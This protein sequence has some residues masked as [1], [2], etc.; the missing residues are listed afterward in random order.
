M[1][2][3][4]IA[5]P[6]VFYPDAV[7]RGKRCKAIC[8]ANGLIGLYPFDNEAD[9]AEAIFAGNCALIDA[10]DI[11]CANLNPFRGD[12]PDS[13]TCFELGYGYARGKELYVYLE[14]VRSLREKLGETDAQ[15][16]SVEDF[17]LPV[18]LMMGIPAKIVSG[19]F[20]ACIAAIVKENK[21]E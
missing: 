15:G 20:A 7:E 2:K 6:D 9:T 17:S 12:E 18:N 21:G 19:D 4:Y 5:G 11:V 3:V 1:K 16:C 13:G 14:D 10:C 8:A